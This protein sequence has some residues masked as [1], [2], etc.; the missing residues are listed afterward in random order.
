LREEFVLTNE[1]KGPEQIQGQ[2][3]SVLN[4]DSKLRHG[5]IESPLCIGKGRSKETFYYDIGE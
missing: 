2:T 1:V 3:E 5:S 4:R